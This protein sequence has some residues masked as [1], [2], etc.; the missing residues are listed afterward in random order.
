MLGFGLWKWGRWSTH[1][2]LNGFVWTDPKF[3]G[4]ALPDWRWLWNGLKQHKMA[5]QQG[6][7]SFFHCQWPPR[8]LFACRDTDRCRMMS[9]VHFQKSLAGVFRGSAKI[10]ILGVRRVCKIRLVES[11]FCWNTDNPRL[12]MSDE[13][14]LVTQLHLVSQELRVLGIMSHRPFVKLCWLN[15]LIL[16]VFRRPWFI[17]LVSG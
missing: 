12:C 6:I 4:Y 14:S 13:H 16:N 9:D 7:P 17:L 5:L 15:L 10:R 8:Q 3:G 2:E 11:S 1:N